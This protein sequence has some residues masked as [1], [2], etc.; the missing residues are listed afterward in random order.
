MPR[1]LKFRGG[2][3]FPW[4]GGSQEVEGPAMTRPAIEFSIKIFI[5]AL[6]A[7]F[8]WTVTKVLGMIGFF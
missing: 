7:T 2:S 8:V 5:V 6:I 1:N 4:R 3:H